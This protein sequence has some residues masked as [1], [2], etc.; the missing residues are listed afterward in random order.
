MRINLL[1][2]HCFQTSKIKKETLLDWILKPHRPAKNKLFTEPSK[3]VCAYKRVVGGVKKNDAVDTCTN[4]RTR[5]LS[6]K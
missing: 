1:H 4:V 3:V 5:S 6:I 2:L